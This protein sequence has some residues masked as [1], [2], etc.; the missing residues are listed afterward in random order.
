MLDYLQPI[1]DTEYLLF[2]DG[3]TTRE[4]GGWG[5]GGQAKS[6]QPLRVVIAAGD[7]AVSLILLPLVY[8]LLVWFGSVLPIQAK[9]DKTELWQLPV[10]SCTGLHTGSRLRGPAV[11]PLCTTG[12]AAKSQ[13]LPACRKVCICISASAGAGPGAGCSPDV[14][15][16]QALRDSQLVC[17]T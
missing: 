2:A 12:K 3:N 15:P 11:L 5:D 8:A 1:P 7:K 10:H 6:S 9:W 14:Q 13:P 16:S 4:C 17:T